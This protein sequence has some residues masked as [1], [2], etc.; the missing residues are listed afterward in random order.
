[1]KSSS[2]PTSFKNLKL[3]GFEVAFLDVL[4]CRKRGGMYDVLSMLLN[5]KRSKSLPTYT[6]VPTSPFSSSATEYGNV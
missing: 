1:M 5:Q 4:L 6:L 2:S 3:T